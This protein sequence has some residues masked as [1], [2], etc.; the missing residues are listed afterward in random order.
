MIELGNPSQAIPYYA[1]YGPEQTEPVTLE[2]FITPG[3]VKDAVEQVGGQS[4]DRQASSPPNSLD[5]Q[6]FSN[7]RLDEHLANHRIVFVNFTGPNSMTCAFNER[8]V[9]DTAQ[10]KA[11]FDEHNVVAL[12]ADIA[13]IPKLVSDELIELGNETRSLPYYAIYS[14][15]IDKP[16]TLDAVL[17]LSTVRQAIKRVSNE[18]TSAKAVASSN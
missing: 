3:M 6:E 7:T 5:W 4:A 9:L 12:R 1:I 2:A 13:Q 11:L 16:V 8:A 17:T 18:N 10:N 15:S 14:S